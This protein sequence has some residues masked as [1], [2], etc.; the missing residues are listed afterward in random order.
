MWEGLGGLSCRKA[1]VL[2]SHWLGTAKSYS[3]LGPQGPGLQSGEAAEWPP[4]LWGQASLLDW[5]GPPQLA[6]EQGE[7]P[8][9]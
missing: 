3:T 9:L 2:S 4:A 7:A 8:G 5:K 6:Q 1:L